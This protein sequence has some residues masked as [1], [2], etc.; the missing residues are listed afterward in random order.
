MRSIDQLNILDDASIAHDLLATINSVRHNQYVM[1]FNEGL[2]LYEKDEEDCMAGLELH[3]RIIVSQ[4]VFV[5]VLFHSMVERYFV[6]H[7]K[8]NAILLSLILSE[9]GS[10]PS[11]VN[12]MA[13][14][15][16]DQ[17]FSIRLSDK[18]RRVFEYMDSGDR[19]GSCR[20]TPDTVL[21]NLSLSDCA[22]ECMMAF[23]C[24]AVESDEHGSCRIFSECN[25]QRI[26][27][28]ELGPY[29]LT[30]VG[31]IQN[32]CWPPTK[33]CVLDM[34]SIM[35]TLFEDTASM[36]YLL[37]YYMEVGDFHSASF[38]ATESASHSD[39]EGV[40]SAGM[41]QLT[42]WEDHYVDVEQASAYFDKLYEG[43][44][45]LNIEEAND[46]SRSTYT[47][48]QRMEIEA[49][50]DIA[51]QIGF[52]DID[53]PDEH[54]MSHSRWV[55][56]IAA[57]VGYSRIAIIQYSYWLPRIVSFVALIPMLLVLLFRRT[58]LV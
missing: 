15:E 22:E 20:N 32:A 35:A 31:R 11:M 18:P 36:N 39:P 30:K 6:T 43:I 27:T 34:H 52:H 5:K 13:L 2:G 8:A 41:L 53:V 19:R 37:H 10:R 23:E 49:A 40:F 51:V 48:F 1:M 21:S 4:S 12:T 58:Y 54:T 24:I 28:D 17:E 55:Q 26:G 38:W 45:A 7:D 33:T 16:H 56:R 44:S 9:M 29:L 46:E 47:S 25:I 42:T 57:V 50:R 14:L 3:H